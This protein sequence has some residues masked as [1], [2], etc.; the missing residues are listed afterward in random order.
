MGAGV[1]DCIYSVFLG[2]VP[3]QTPHVPVGPRG[4]HT[5]KTLADEGDREF[6][7]VVWEWRNVFIPILAGC[8]IQCSGKAF[9]PTKPATT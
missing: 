6:H 1:V 4:A 3:S 9:A 7:R 5:S 2:L 8:E